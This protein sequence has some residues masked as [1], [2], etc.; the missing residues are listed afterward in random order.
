MDAYKHLFMHYGLNPIAG[1]PEQDVEDA[2][3][4]LKRK[5]EAAVSWPIAGIMAVLTLIALLSSKPLL[6][7]LPAVGFVTALVL[8]Q[9]GLG[10]AKL[11][12]HLELGQYPD[13]A[14]GPPLLHTI[15]SNPE[16][17]ATAQSL[18]DAQGGVLYHFQ[19][20]ALQ[21]RSREIELVRFRAGEGGTALT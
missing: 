2:Y 16:L 9:N 11:R 20:R 5:E 19:M 1:S 21:E 15:N 18:L 12:Y 6:G 17:Q 10:N 14:F 4:A 8:Y 13:R 7:I 3:M